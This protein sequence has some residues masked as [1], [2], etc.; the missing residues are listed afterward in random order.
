[1]HNQYCFISCKSLKNRN[2]YSIWKY[3]NIHSFATEFFPLKWDDTDKRFCF[4]GRAVILRA[5]SENQE[6]FISHAFI[7][8]WLLLRSV[9][10]IVCYHRKSK[11]Y[12]KQ[13]SRCGRKKYAKSKQMFRTSNL[14]FDI[15]P[16]ARHQSVVFVI[17]M[18]AFLLFVPRAYQFHVFRA[19]VKQRFLNGQKNFCQIS[20][21]G[22][23]W[24]F[25]DHLRPS[26][27]FKM[28]GMVGLVNFHFESS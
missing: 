14:M 24:I 8:N 1:M 16:L 26:I 28:I 6:E 21:T 11:Y 2:F 25:N 18:R 13:I 19:D 15:N 9:T 10:S 12:Q 3:K 7:S 23:L 4:R 27:R 5:Q 17:S 20:I 22:C